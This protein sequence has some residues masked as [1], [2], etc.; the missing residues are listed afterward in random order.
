NYLNEPARHKLLDVIGDSALLGL[1]LQG[2]IIAYK[3][4]HTFN[5]QC[6]RRLRNQILSE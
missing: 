4:G 1:R 2:R 6:I 3:P 5:T